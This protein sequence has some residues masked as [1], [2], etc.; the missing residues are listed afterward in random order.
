MQ[1]E[2]YVIVTKGNIKKFPIDKRNR[3]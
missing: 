3:F 1:D 2:R